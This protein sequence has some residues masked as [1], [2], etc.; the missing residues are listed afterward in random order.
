MTD[1]LDLV[2]LDQVTRIDRDFRFIREYGLEKPR[3]PSTSPTYSFDLEGW[4]IG[5]DS[6]LESVELL[7]DDT[8]LWRIPAG[9]ERPDVATRKGL[10]PGEHTIGFYGPV[11]CL[12]LPTE[13]DC[14][15]AAVVQDGNRMHIAEIRGARAPLR[16]G[17]E[18][19]LRPLTVTTLGRTGSSMFLR[20]LEAHP[21]IVAYRPLE[22]EPR[23]LEYW[24]EVF[25]SLS[26]PA[27]Y[28]N[29]LDPP[30]DLEAERLVVARRAARGPAQDRLPGRRAGARGMDGAREP[31]PARRHVPIADRGRLRADRGAA[32]Q[33]AGLL[34]REARP[35]TTRRRSCRSC[36]RAHARSS[37]CATSV[38]WSARCSPSTSSAAV[39]SCSAA[40][41][42]LDQRGLR[43]RA[44]QERQ[45]CACS[46]AGP[47][48]ATL[49]TSC[50]TRTCCSNRRRRSTTCSPTSGSKW[51]GNRAD[52]A[53]HVA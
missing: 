20:V 14:V 51:R 12:R 22:Y 47:G 13:F 2:R 29:Q 48:A 37:W 36:I 5:R 30:I 45:C 11:N 43:A 25:L 26:E 35:G 3:A 1:R 17:F 40:R 28:L 7:L 4:A 19:A 15:L 50:A 44:G 9:V 49:P 53:A 8:R 34:R 21:E 10:P 42:R 32:T 6:P 24:M 38:T 16:S 27:S 52:A 31:R 23:T 18:A 41:S 39:A 46:G 33:A